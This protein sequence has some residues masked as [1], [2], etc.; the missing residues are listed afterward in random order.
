[1]GERFTSTEPE[2]PAGFTQEWDRVYTAWAQPYDLAVRLLPVWKTWLRH[3]LPHIEGPRVLEV[4]F[5]TGYLIS[6][7]ADE[8]ETHGLDYNRA[9]ATTARRNLVRVG[10]A[11]NLV[12]GN[13]EQLPYTD[14]AFDSLLNTMAFSGYPNGVRALN[15][16]KRVLRVGGKLVLIDFTY[17]HDRNWLGTKLAAWVENSGDVLRDMRALFDECGFEYTDTP[18]G[19]WRS[20]RLY[21]ATRTA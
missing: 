12:Q 10:K 5:G 8:F 19:G 7:Y 18:I 11:A 3:A 20:V 17:P 1:M 21:V 14:G 4:S 13:V 16:M 6:Q 2:D 15:E 9:M